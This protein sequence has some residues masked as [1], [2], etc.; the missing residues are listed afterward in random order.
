MSGKVGI[1]TL[2]GQFNYGNR[3]QLFATTRVYERLGYSPV[4]I[5]FVHRDSLFEAA[6]K[7]VKGI[8]RFVRGESQYVSPES[9]STEGRLDAFSRFGRLFETCQVL[10]TDEL[11]GS[12]FDYFSVGSDQIWNPYGIVDMSDENPL[13]RLIYRWVLSERK[14]RFLNWN[15]LGFCP[16]N[17]RIAL[18]PSI[19]LD[20][21]DN[22]QSELLASGVGNFNRISVREKRGAELVKAFSGLDA[23]VICDPTLQLTADEWRSVAGDG[24]T[25]D[26]SYVFTYLL[27]DVGAQAAGVLDEVTDHGRIPI[28]PL[29]ANQAPGEPDAGPAEFIDLIDHATHVVTD[30]FHAAVF[31]SILQTPLTIVHREGGASMFS[32][33]EQLSEM[34]GIEEKVYGSPTYDLARAG[35]YDGV[36]EAIEREREKFMAYLEGCLDG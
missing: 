11:N 3:L 12:D 22:C 26:G 13:L 10:D 16:R 21:L 32:R 29:T 9:L 28:I 14:E 27:G 31:S 17:K 18:A 2:A 35:E 15:F 33:L 1:V 7:R 5:E 6:G 25:P 20:H 36:P 34:L 24:C 8:A 4:Y 19:G 30:S 23:E